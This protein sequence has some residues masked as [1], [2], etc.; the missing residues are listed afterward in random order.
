[1]VEDYHINKQ[2]LGMIGFSYAG[3]TRR[4]LDRIS[5]IISHLRNKTGYLD[6]CS[7]YDY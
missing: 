2:I 5:A 3:M 7:Q 1:M 4:E 6:I